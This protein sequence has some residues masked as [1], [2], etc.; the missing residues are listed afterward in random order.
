MSIRALLGQKV[1]GFHPLT[2]RDGFGDR[3]ASWQSK[4][5]YLTVGRV[6][7]RVIRARTDHHGRNVHE[8]R[9]RI[10][11]PADAPVQEQDRLRIDGVDF[12]EVVGVYPVNHPRQGVHHFLIE[13]HSVNH[14]EAY[15]G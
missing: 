1:E 2:V 7:E 14:T 10:Q 15:G 8:E 4:P 5:D 11:L 13:A 6:A 9:W 12:V 3:R